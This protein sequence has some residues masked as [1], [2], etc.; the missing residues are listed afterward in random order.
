MTTSKAR[1]NGLALVLLASVAAS[2]CASTSTT[3][4]PPNTH[5]SARRSAED[6]ASLQEG[7]PRE[8]NDP[9]VASIEHGTI[10]LMPYCKMSPVE[11]DS[12]A[13]AALEDLKNHGIKETAPHVLSELLAFYT[14]ADSVTRK[15]TCSQAAAIYL[16]LREGHGG[17]E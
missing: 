13:N 12:T 9:L 2:G 3:P 17:S 10:A 4:P 6:L 11:I 8:A 15:T 16:S 5:S 7:G 14:H 1:R